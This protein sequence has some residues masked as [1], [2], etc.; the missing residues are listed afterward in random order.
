MISGET[1]R[2]AAAY[3]ASETRTRDLLGAIQ[4]LS[5]LSYSPGRRR[6][7]HG[8]RASL[9]P[10]GQRPL[11][12]WG[13][14]R[15]DLGE[16]P[17]TADTLGKREGTMSFRTR[18]TS[19]FVLIVVIPM[20][21]V[22]F[23]VFRLIG[24]SQTGKAEARAAGIAATAESVYLTSSATASLD[25][26][27][28]AR[29]VTGIPPRRLPARL[30]VIARETGLARVEVTVGAR[31]P[32]SVGDPTAVAPG[33][34]VVRAAGTRP[35][36]TIAAAELTAGAYARSLRGSGIEAVVRSGGR[37]VAATLPA[38]AHAALP[39][40]HG[41]ITLGAHDYH[42][43]TQGFSG[44][45][46]RQVEVSVLSD[47]SVTNGPLATDRVL[48]AAFI[49]AFLILAFFFALLASRALQAQLA[50]FLEAARRLGGGDFS[51]AIPTTGSDEFAA[52]GEEFNSMSRQ[53]EHRL[54]ELEQERSRVR[55]AIRRIGEAFASG[56]D[57]DALLALSLQSALD[58]ADAD[59][60][61]ISARSSPEQ[62]LTEARRIGRL[63]GLETPLIEA[64]RQALEGQGVAV[65]SDRDLHLATVALGEMTPGGPR[66]GVITVC[67]EGRPF[68]DDDLALLRSLANQ[69]TL[70][71]ANVNLHLETQRQAVT[72]DLTGLASHGRFQDLLDAE[73]EQVRRYHYPVGLIMLDIDD[74]KS[75]NDIHG[76]PQG[77]IVLRHVAEALRETSRDVDVAAR[78]GGEEMALILPHTDLDGTYE[79]AERTRTAIEAL[80]IPRL[81]G[82]GSLKIT[83]SVGAAASAEGNK[84]DLIAAADNALYMAKH[85]G[86]NRTVRAHPETA[87]VSAGE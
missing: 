57:R 86:K 51:S 16:R 5:Q 67:R 8:D 11:V 63:A 73:M 6:R 4:A 75:V 29:D 13:R 17:K 20:A 82:Q 39:A 76:H 9:V 27:T 69:A 40:G 70:A 44:F 43:V 34:A 87:N 42:V 19:F 81:E 72:D 18:L 2:P 52:L 58:A 77:D 7:P 60:G 24:D 79:M 49:L 33:V 36:S 66:H 30:A 48:A 41:S 31:R 85:E 78:Y 56:L 61:R 10:I 59:R 3:G 23:L 15:P 55:S 47:D 80:V 53:L 62:A 25:A 1:T 37:T 28:I 84:E 35:S 50:R 65:A 74:F 46:H 21:A 64:E 26:R 45:D 14:C 68:S 32:V 22:G 83:A 38:A 71:L 54:R 12:H